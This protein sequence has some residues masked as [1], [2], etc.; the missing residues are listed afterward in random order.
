LLTSHAV[1]VDFHVQ[2][3][4]VGVAG[5]AFFGDNLDAFG[6]AL[7]QVSESAGG[8]L[9]ARLRPVH[10]WEVVFG[11]G[12]DRPEDPVLLTRNNSAYSSLTF[13][14]TPEVATSFEY[15]WLETTAGVQKRGNHH[16][17]WALAYSF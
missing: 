10:R 16:F 17:N 8:F 11:G 12:T 7:S 5:E 1:A 9:E 3:E 14:P 6:G 13:R 2:G 4:R 15:R